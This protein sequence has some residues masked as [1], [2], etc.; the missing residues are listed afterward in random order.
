[1]AQNTEYEVGEDLKRGETSLNFNVDN[2]WGGGGGFQLGSTLK[3]F[4]FMAWM[5]AGNSMRDT[6]DAS[7]NNYD[8]ARFP[9]YWL[10]SGYAKI[11]TDG[12]RPMKALAINHNKM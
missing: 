12:W 7:R 2:Q 5:G 6:V 9:A 11:G 1:M 10:D 3:P 8:G 4:V